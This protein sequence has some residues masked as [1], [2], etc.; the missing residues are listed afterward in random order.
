MEVRKLQLETR[1][2]G[3][4]RGKTR[5]REEPERKRVCGV[6]PGPRVGEGNWVPGVRSGLRLLTGQ[7]LSGQRHFHHFAR[8][9]TWSQLWPSLSFDTDNSSSAF[10]PTGQCRV[11]AFGWHLLNTTVSTGLDP[12]QTT[13]ICSYPHHHQARFMTRPPADS[14]VGHSQICYKFLMKPDEILSGA[15]SFQNTKFRL[16]QIAGD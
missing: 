12:F 10:F 15:P 13:G 6:K 8:G 3:E 1:R 11:V 4:K 16:A 2:E 14:D 7:L 9:G 5:G